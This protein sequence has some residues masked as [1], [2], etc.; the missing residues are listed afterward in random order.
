MSILT[1]KV[2]QKGIQ[3][4]RCVQLTPPQYF[5]PDSDNHVKVV[6]HPLALNT[7]ADDEL[8]L[9][10]RRSRRRIQLPIRLADFLPHSL[11]ELPPDNVDHGNP[12]AAS[13]QPLPFARRIIQTSKNAF[14]LFRKYTNRLPN[15]D[16]EELVDLASLTEIAD[17]HDKG[18]DGQETLTSNP[19][20]Y[21]FPNKSSF[22][23]SEW[24]WSDGAQK[25]QSSFKKMVGMIY[26]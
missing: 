5:S 26:N 3:H 1:F 25:S 9:A 15:H 19:S 16:P 17:D 24:Y 18:D 8:S 23:L 10:Q 20:F 14:G 11:T 12:E 7:Q 13:P 6:N 4:Q 21:P 22:Q 2:I